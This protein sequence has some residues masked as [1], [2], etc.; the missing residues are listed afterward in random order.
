MT[1]AELEKTLLKD[2]NLRAVTRH[3]REFQWVY[4]SIRSYFYFCSFYVLVVN[5]G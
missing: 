1:K 3:L 2:T 5:I 4:L